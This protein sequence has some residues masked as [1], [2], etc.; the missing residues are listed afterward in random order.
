MEG[1][2]IFKLSVAAFARVSASSLSN[3]TLRADKSQIIM[4]FTRVDRLSFTLITSVCFF[5][6]EFISCKPD[7]LALHV[8]R[9]DVSELCL[10][11]HHACPW[12]RTLQL[13]FPN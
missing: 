8:L 10:S 13:P 3:M 1:S 9:V 11:I 2:D 4:R 7:R 6:L 12:I 5:L